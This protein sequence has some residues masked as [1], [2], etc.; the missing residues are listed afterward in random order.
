MIYV[1]IVFVCVQHRIQVNALGTVA[2]SVSLPEWYQTS[3]FIPVPVSSEWPYLLCFLIC[4]GYNSYFQ[5][6]A[7]LITYH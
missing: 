3:L 7:E 5:S 6:K 1:Q 2:M 4:P